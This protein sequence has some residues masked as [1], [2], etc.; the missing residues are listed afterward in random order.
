MTV[1]AGMSATLLRTT[2]TITNVGLFAFMLGLA[3]IEQEWAN[4]QGFC[5]T[6]KAK[7]KAWRVVLVFQVAVSIAIVIYA[8]RVS[9]SH[10][11]STASNWHALWKAVPTFFFSYCSP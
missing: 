8:S 11:T 4:L 6:K 7:K 3:D 10:Q 1:S 9:H 5:W 2:V